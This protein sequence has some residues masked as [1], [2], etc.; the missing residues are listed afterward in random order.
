MRVE[1]LRACRL[2]GYRIDP[3]AADC[4]GVPSK[5]EVARLACRLRQLYTHAFNVV[6]RREAR[7]HFRTVHV[8]D[9]LR[10]YARGDRIGAV[11]VGNRRLDGILDRECK[12][13]DTF[14]RRRAGKHVA[15]ARK[16]GWE[17]RILECEQVRTRTAT[18]RIVKIQLEGF[19]DVSGK[20]TRRLRK[21]RNASLA[22]DIIPQT[23]QSDC[24]T[25]SELR[26]R[27]DVITGLNHHVCTD[28]KRAIGTTSIALADSG[29]IT[30]AVGSNSSAVD[31][32]SSTASLITTAN[33]SAKIAALGRHGSVVH[34]NNA[35]VAF[36]SSS[37]ARTV[38]SA[39][40]RHGAAVDCN[41]SGASVPFSTYA[42]SQGAA[43]C[44]NSASPSRRLG[45]DCQR[46]SVQNVDARLVA[47]VAC[48]RKRR[49]VRKDYAGVA[50]NRDECGNP[51]IVLHD[52]PACFKRCRI[53]VDLSAF[54]GRL[55][56]PC[57]VYVCLVALHSAPLGVENLV[58]CR[59]VRDARCGS[60]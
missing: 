34:D 14:R 40:R 45:V 59:A 49:A 46:V 36:A 58:A 33:A 6:R 10:S 17:R 42:G 19:A 3:V 35:A 51:H 48:Y 4:R 12:R 7:H 21:G 29:T 27:S 5:V 13:A 47:I 53:R 9:R 32:H 41:R 15:R 57:G 22:Y 18:D 30:R 55:N 24:A 31:R 20:S 23:I 52:I 60:A 44:V 43:R 11:Q 1:G 39:G 25:C 37:D 50:R 26:Q 28:C 54:H 8:G 38:V 56:R 16:P 2:G